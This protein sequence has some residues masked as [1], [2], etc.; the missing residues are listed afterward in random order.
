MKTKLL[1]TDSMGFA[2]APFVLEYKS[3]ELVTQVDGTKVKASEATSIIL[4]FTCK[5]PIDHGL[6]TDL[7]EHYKVPA[8]SYLKWNTSRPEELE[9]FVKIAGRIRKTFRRNRQDIIEPSAYYIRS[10]SV[11]PELESLIMLAGLGRPEFKGNRYLIDP[12]LPDHMDFFSHNIDSWLNL[13]PI[14]LEDAPLQ[15]Q[16]WYLR[17]LFE[18]FAF[19]SERP[20]Y[21]N[22]FSAELGPF[23]RWHTKRGYDLPTIVPR[24]LKRFGIVSELYNEYSKDMFGRARHENDIENIICVVKRENADRFIRMIGVKDYDIYII[25]KALCKLDTTNDDALME[26]WFGQG[27]IDLKVVRRISC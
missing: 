8:W 2:R 4:P 27:F 13:F 26:R 17:E 3:D 5:P 22:G 23:R 11:D 25:R 18:P 16:A 20:Y 9:A 21:H 12:T 6:D 1:L 19:K 24:M 15:V 14:V 10:S 7:T